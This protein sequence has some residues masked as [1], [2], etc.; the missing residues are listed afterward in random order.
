MENYLS[1][2]LSVGCQEENLREY[3]DESAPK[4]LHA[5]PLH[6]RAPLLVLVQAARW[7]AVVSA[8]WDSSAI[9]S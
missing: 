2:T 8:P 1:Q 3:Q 5:S 9:F 6:F 7:R 4:L